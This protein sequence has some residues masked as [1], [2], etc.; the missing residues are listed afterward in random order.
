MDIL[1]IGSGYVGLVTAACFASMGHIVHCFDIDQEKIAQLRRGISPIYEPGLQELMQQSVQGNRLFFHHTYPKLKTI[2]VAFLCVSTPSNEDGSCNT[3]Y[4]EKAA[5]DLAKHL[6]ETTLI[7]N[8]STAPI[9]TTRKLKGLIQKHSSTKARFKIA[10]NPEFLKEGSAISDCM[11]P[12]RIIIGVDDP[13]SESILRKLYAPFT[14]SFER[15][16]VTDIASAELIKYASN[17]ALSARISFANEIAKISEKIG[18]DMDSVRRGIGSDTRIGY[19][20]LYAGL[21]YGGSC[22]P[23]DIRALIHLA[24]ELEVKTPLLEA[25]ET[26]NNRQKLLAIQILETHFAPFGGLENKTIAIWGLSFKPDTDDVREAPAKVILEHLQKKGVQIRTFDPVAMENMRKALAS[27]KGLT[28][29]KNAYDAAKDAD[30]ICLVTEWKE[31]RLI[32]F[33][34]IA[35]KKQA[36]VLDGRNQY[37]QQELTKYGFIYVGIG[38]SA[39]TATAAVNEPACSLS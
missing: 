33:S 9:G 19:H 2:D 36:L 6:E 21:G 24:K 34:K 35:A 23:K 20:F 22:F 10:S 25:V 8:K 1:I 31:F 4:L 16:L 7:V 32:D 30:A 15:V 14:M 11:K 12:D 28:F 13:I 29:C 5:I 3:S 27:T 17:A 18:A 39:K 26:V 37:D 38:K